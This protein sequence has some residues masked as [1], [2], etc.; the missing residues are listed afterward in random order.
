MSL[1]EG[2]RVVVLQHDAYVLPG[3]EAFGVQVCKHSSHPVLE[4]PTF[5]P[6]GAVFSSWVSP[7]GETTNGYSQR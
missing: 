2:S 5:M 1:N 3:V 4:Q 6:F 7:K